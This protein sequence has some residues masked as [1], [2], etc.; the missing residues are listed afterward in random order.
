MDRDPGRAEAYCLKNAAS[1]LG[2]A[3]GRGLNR[4]FNFEHQA[5]NEIVNKIFGDQ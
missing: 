1:K 5:D 2:N 3:F 4:D